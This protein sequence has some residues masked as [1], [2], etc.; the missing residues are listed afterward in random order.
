MDYTSQ[1]HKNTNQIVC[2]GGGGLKTKIATRK[3]L[4][5]TCLL[6]IMVPNNYT[7]TLVNVNVDKK[8]KPLCNW[9]LSQLGPCSFKEMKEIHW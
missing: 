6:F 4:G 8:K 1:N 3:G 2:G 5:A 7:F 9:L